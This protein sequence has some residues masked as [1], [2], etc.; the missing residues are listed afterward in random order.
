MYLT[1]PNPLALDLT[2]SGAAP[3][4]A[5]ADTRGPALVATPVTGH[6]AG[7]NLVFTFDEPVQLAEGVLVL[8]S[9]WNRV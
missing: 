3:A 8:E 4:A 1:S 5:S 9:G 7:D 2:Q 6:P